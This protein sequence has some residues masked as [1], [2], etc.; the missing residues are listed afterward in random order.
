MKV[1]NTKI[2]NAIIFEPNLFE[3]ERGFFLESWNEEIFKE[4][5]NKKTRFVQ[6]NHSFSKKMSLEDCTIK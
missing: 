3:D 2:E 6:D 1:I 4:Y 5:F